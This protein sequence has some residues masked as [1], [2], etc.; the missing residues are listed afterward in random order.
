MSFNCIKPY[1]GQGIVHYTRLLLLTY[2]RHESYEFCLQDHVPSFL[3][4]DEDGRVLRA[5]TFSKVFGGGYGGA[6]YH[7][8]YV[9]PL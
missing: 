2:P 5:D 7:Q 8:T 3:S 6:E 4:M 1:F 9:V